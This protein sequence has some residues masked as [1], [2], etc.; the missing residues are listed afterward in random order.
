M[1]APPG[2]QQLAS[3]P[4]P[5]EQV[6]GAAGLPF[7][8]TVVRRMPLVRSAFLVVLPTLLALQGS[9]LG[10]AGVPLSRLLNPG[11]AVVLVLT[12]ALVAWAVLPARRRLTVAGGPGWVARRTF[13]GGPWRVVRL[14]DVD[15]FSA[16]RYR[17]R[18]G[19]YWSVTLR[20]RDGSQT[21]LTLP[22]EDRA[23]DALAT[24]LTAVGGRRTPPLRSGAT[25][26]RRLGL[27]LAI[28][29]VG[30]APMALV[31]IGPYALLPDRVAVYFSSSGCRAAAAAAHHAPAASP[32]VTLLAAEQVGRATWQFRGDWPQDVPT[33]AAGTADP[34]ARQQRLVTDGVQDIHHVQYSGPTG[35]V[36]VVTTLSFSTVA[37][38][39]DYDAYV[40]RA[41]CEGYAGTAGPAPHEVRL[42]A[43]RCAVDRWLSGRTIYSLAQATAGPQAS[44]DDVE[45]LAV[46]LQS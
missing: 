18:G 42:R 29:A 19:S 17:T 46:A 43:G 20:L 12:T 40:N 6:T 21:S 32:G 8:A 45:S 7:P 27:V 35:A 2:E 37:G 11:V 5:G 4:P 9:R 39:A 3:W 41:V 22:F 23:A 15:E 24:A 1:T 16:S 36:I 10:R 31:A 44:P 28:I 26:L 25:L 33:Y 14:A 34:A 38:A 13:P 30:A